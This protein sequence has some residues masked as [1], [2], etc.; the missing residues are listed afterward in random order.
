MQVF[1]GAGDESALKYELLGV[2]LL[3]LLALDRIAEFH[4]ELEVIPVARRGQ[5]KFI[6]YPMAMEQF[7]MEGAYHRAIQGCRQTPSKL[8]DFVAHILGQT[9][10]LQIAECVSRAY[11][12]L[13]AKELAALLML[14]D[15][16]DLAAFEQ[17]FGWHKDVNGHYNFSKSRAPDAEESRVP[18]LSIMAQTLSFATELEKII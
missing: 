11:T 2:N 18:K 9:V 6:Q 7:I 15:H 17:K 4:T 16:K 3:R 5:E 13:T 10:R 14:H 8:F 12:T 1:Y